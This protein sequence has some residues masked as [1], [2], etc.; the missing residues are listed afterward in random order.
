[1]PSA[2]PRILALLLFALFA[3]SSA[4]AQI[5]NVDD[6]TSTPSPG[7]GHDYIHLL[8]ETVNPANGSVSLRIEVPMPKGRGWRMLCF[9]V[10]THGR[11]LPVSDMASIVSIAFPG[12]LPLRVSARVGSFFFLFP[13]TSNASP[14]AAICTL[15][16]SLAIGTGIFWRPREI[17]TSRRKFSVKSA[18]VSNSHWSGT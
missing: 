14:D 9:T 1:M 13:I 3:S 8:S 16:P 15:L 2:R 11:L 17:E 5:T 7:A 12:G 10:F 18:P 4:R 6:T